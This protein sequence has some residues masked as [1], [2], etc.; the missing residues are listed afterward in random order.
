MSAPQSLPP[1][2]DP[3]ATSPR[4]DDANLGRVVEAL[5]HIVRAVRV[6]SH[7]AESSLG[8][9]G[10]QLFVLQELAALT[11]DRRGGA[12]LGDIA[13][14]T[15]THQSSV[16]VVVSRLVRAGYV[17]K[18]VSADDG[19]RA[20]LRLTASGRAVLRRAPELAHTRMVAALRGATR[21]DLR[22]TARVLGDV[23]RHLGAGTEPAE[24]FFEG[25]GARGAR[26]RGAK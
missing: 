7:G 15:L 5:R 23:A 18:G 2:P 4:K 17:E 9:S 13:E 16:S 1:G 8:L 22:A 24:M 21:A 26:G 6:S 14:R 20:E 11:A 25:E 12:S 3:R 10:A 19:R